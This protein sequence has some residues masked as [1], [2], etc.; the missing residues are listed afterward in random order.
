[1]LPT[2]ETFLLSNL[3]H[4]VAEAQWGEIIFKELPTSVSKKSIPSA[5]VYYYCAWYTFFCNRHY[6]ELVISQ[7][8]YGSEA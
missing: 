6:N 4:S 3:A 2:H 5:V 1:M 8:I 7:N